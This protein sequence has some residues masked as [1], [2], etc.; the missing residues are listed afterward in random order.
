[1]TTTPLTQPTWAHTALLSAADE[2]TQSTWFDPTDV[3]DPAWAI[4][5]TTSDALTGPD[6]TEGAAAG[7][8]EAAVP[9]TISA[10]VPPLDHVTYTAVAESSTLMGRHDAYTSSTP[11]ADAVARLSMLAE[12]LCSSA[13]EGIHS[14]VVDV[15]AAL[16]DP[17]GPR[18]TNDAVWLVA[19]LYRA[20]E[21][22]D[23]AR[24]TD[25]GQVASSYVSHELHKTLMQRSRPQIAGVVRSGAV[26]I[27]GPF[28]RTPHTASYVAPNAAGVAAALVDLDTWTDRGDIAPLAQVAI[29]H[30]QFETIHPYAD[31]NGRIGRTLMGAWL[32]RAD[33]VEGLV[34]A[35]IS[36]GLAARRREYVDALIAYR[37]GDLAPI[38]TVTTD[39]IK[40]GVHF[41][42][43]LTSH[44]SNIRARWTEALT[45]RPDAVVWRILDTALAGHV[46]NAN[47]LA[48]DLDVSY[49]TAN[50]AIS[51]LVDI[52]ALTLVSEQRRNR[53]FVA[54]EVTDVVDRLVLAAVQ[55]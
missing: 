29:A 19:D 41:A 43:V 17:R 1:M 24:F 48:Y 31:G 39:A 46:I 42:D 20:I 33:A 51:L 8:Y 49:P 21:L 28:C 45:A 36:Y 10:L 15:S 53:A 12:A 26:W 35:P 54:T 52:G 32:R 38:V 27:G 22:A 3:T 13:I 2:P 25:V 18:R 30:A 40:A 16:A 37:H 11:V 55:R 4:T 5:T 50:A 9:A 23:E 34:M 7:T 6:G 14:N 47:D 44:L